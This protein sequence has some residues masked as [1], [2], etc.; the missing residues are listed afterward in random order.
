MFRNHLWTIVA[1]KSGTSGLF[2]RA[3]VLYGRSGIEMLFKGTDSSLVLL[4]AL[5]KGDENEEDLDMG[6]ELLTC[7][8]AGP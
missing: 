3:G 1:W 7:V 8:G 2:E 5:H 6:G 4:R